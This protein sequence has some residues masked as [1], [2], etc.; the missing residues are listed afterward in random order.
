MSKEKNK[1]KKNYNSLNAG[2]FIIASLF[3]FIPSFSFAQTLIYEND[4]STSALFSPFNGIRIQSITASSSIELQGFSLKLATATTT[5]FTWTAN[6]GYGTGYT[7]SSTN[8]WFATTTGSS[9]AIQF[10][11]T[12]TTAWYQI[13]FPASYIIPAGQPVQVK[14]TATSSFSVYSASENIVADPTWCNQTGCTRQ[15]AV[16]L[17]GQVSSQLVFF[18]A[19]TNGITTEDFDNWIVSATGLN[20]GEGY[21]FKVLYG[22][23]TSTIGTYA[24]IGGGFTAANTVTTGNVG[25]SISLIPFSALATTSV[26]WSARPVLYTSSSQIVGTDITFTVQRNAGF[27]NQPN[28]NASSIINYAST[29]LAG[30][31]LECPDFNFF[32]SS[33]LGTIVCWG[34]KG[35]IGLLSFLFQ[36]NPNVMEYLRVTITGFQ[37]VFPFNLTFGTLNASQSIVENQNQ[38]Q[39]TLVWNFDP[40]GTHNTNV[41]LFAQDGLENAIGASAKLWFD[42]IVLFL[43]LIG[44]AYMI[45]R[46]AF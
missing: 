39:T 1:K 12:G 30:P 40:D 42:N 27:P 44:F 9:A 6:I 21:S 35:F 8:T 11:S 24:D 38:T 25:K 31:A 2:A 37:N 22:E 16:R 15:G 4:E 19:P 34:Q 33:T 18:S 45:T 13:L 46:I 43:T 29:T 10:S 17:Y 5:P 7:N 41:T 36:P 32:S 28:W 3:F 14:F 26:Q 20:I 23:T